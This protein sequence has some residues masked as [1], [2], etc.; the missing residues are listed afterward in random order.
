MTIKPVLVPDQDAKTLRALLETFDAAAAG[1]AKKQLNEMDYGG[2]RSP[3]G[4]HGLPRDDDDADAGKKEIMVKPETAKKATKNASDALNKAFDASYDKKGV[5]EG[6]FGDKAG[7]EINHAAIGKLSDEE[8]QKA[9]KFSDSFN[10]DPEHA[11]TAKAL[12]AEIKKRKEQGVAEAAPKITGHADYTGKDLVKDANRLFTAGGFKLADKQVEPRS[13]DPKKINTIYFWRKKIP[14][15][16]V[17]ELMIEVYNYAPHKTYYAVN[18]LSKDGARVTPDLAQKMWRE[19]EFQI[20]DMSSQRGLEEG[21]GMSRAAKGYEK[22]G[23]AGMQA[24]AQAGREGRAL[25]PIRAKYD[26]Y[27]EGAESENLAIGEKMARDGIEYDPAREGEIISMI[28]DY[29][30]RDGMTT[31]QVRGYMID[32]DFISDQLSYLPRKSGVAE[33]D[34]PYNDPNL[35]KA[36][37]LGN[38][39]Y[40]ALKNDPARAQAAQDKI[41]AEFPQYARMWLTGYRDGERFDQEKSLKES[42]DPLEDLRRLL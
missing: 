40:K 10:I 32:P 37:R 21:G 20:K 28:G 18:D 3:H 25:D 42:Q 9:Y 7:R 4:G 23:K 1:T 19:M 41:E 30:R 27:D 22:Y 33:A 35:A 5:E 31:R 12:R 13:D 2:G 39:A 34:V 38:E 36:Y 17:Q 14:G 11:A 29:L 24:L 26:R 16:G 8:L 15:L 6:L